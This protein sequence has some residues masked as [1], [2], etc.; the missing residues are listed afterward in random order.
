MRKNLQKIG[1][2]E[3]HE[4]VGVFSRQGTKNGFKGPVKTV[5]LIDVRTTDG[6]IVTDHLWFNMTKGFEI[7]NLKE[8]DVIGFAARVSPYEKGYKGSRDDIYEPISIDYRLSYPTK[9]HKMT[10]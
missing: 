3:R 4:F 9:I 7:L 1:S 6:K 5:L 2:D 10:D 8:G